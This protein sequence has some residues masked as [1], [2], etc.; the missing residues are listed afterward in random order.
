MYTLDVGMSHHAGN[1]VVR[2]RLE[3][4]PIFATA[5]RSQT[6]CLLLACP[7]VVPASREES[8]P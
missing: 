8:D 3:V 1:A 6:V 2:E 5:R 4:K 7:Q